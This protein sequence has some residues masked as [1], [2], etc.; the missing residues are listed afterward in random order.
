M[1]CFIWYCFSTAFIVA[2]YIT[3]FMLYNI[4]NFYTQWQSVFKDFKQIKFYYYPYYCGTTVSEQVIEG[5]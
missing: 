4:V 3:N 5:R 2:L 1:D